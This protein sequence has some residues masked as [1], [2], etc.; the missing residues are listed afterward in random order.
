M[1]VSR[2]LFNFTAEEDGSN[3]WHEGWGGKEARGR[4]GEE[5]EAKLKNKAK[6]DPIKMV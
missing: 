2:D 4:E 6:E 3:R 1:Q 5:E